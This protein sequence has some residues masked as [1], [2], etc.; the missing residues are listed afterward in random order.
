M[1]KQCKDVL[2]QLRK[3]SNST[4]D[5]LCFMSDNSHIYA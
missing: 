1:T 4:D 2:K 5:E 3:I